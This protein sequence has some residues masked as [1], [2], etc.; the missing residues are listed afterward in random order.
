[1]VGGGDSVTQQ[2]STLT[3][4][5]L[6]TSHNN[7]V[8]FF[9][10]NNP[11]LRDSERKLEMFSGTGGYDRPKRELEQNQMFAPVKE[12]IYGTPNLP[13]EL[14]KERFIQSNLKTN[15]LPFPQV[16]VA[17]GLNQEGFGSKGADGFH[18]MFRPHIRNVDELRPLSN[19]KVQYEGRVIVGKR[20]SALRRGQIGQVS[21]NR[22]DRYYVNEP[23]RWGIGRANNLEALMEQD[24]A[25]ALQCTDSGFEIGG[26][27]GPAATHV[28]EARPGMEKADYEGRPLQEGFNKASGVNSLH[29]ATYKTSHQNQY[30]RNVA[31]PVK[32]N[33]NANVAI[34]YL[35][36][37]MEEERATTEPQTESNQL[38]VRGAVGEGQMQFFDKAQQT[39]A[40]T[41]S[42][43]DTQ[44]NL[45]GH[46]AD[47]QGYETADYEADFQPTNKQFTSMRGYSGVANRSEIGQ[48]YQRAI[49]DGVRTTTRETVLGALDYTGI[50]RTEAGEPM[51]YA[52][53]F[54]AQRDRKYVNN[55]D[56]KGAAGTA[57][58]ARLVNRENYNNAI[59][60]TRQ[61]RLLHQR[62]PT[63]EKSKNI[64]VG[65]QNITIHARNQVSGIPNQYALSG[66]TG[67]SSGVRPMAPTGEFK[68][69]TTFRHNADQNIEWR[70]DPSILDQFRSNPFTQ[71]L[72][73]Y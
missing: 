7:Q 64:N 25:T 63:Q 24:F 15:V 33:N 44:L 12:N 35:P 67:G 9:S 34:N 2:V 48:G 57:Q 62:A 72:H 55:P 27:Q 73:S 56:Y 43:T 66:G 16:R 46:R 26:L 69:L 52:K 6:D 61:E 29:R 70:I 47:G 1:V 23:A 59:I 30:Q 17:P 39:I 22:P 53:Y 19:P 60:R 41:L 5:S 21:K 40:D 28:T 71:S 20:D 36:G 51:S 45:K 42:N 37:I 4:Q 14:R 11:I 3:G 49:V 31:A 8:P 38:N 50:A 54:A 58:S 13:D 18:S 10:G 32:D 65:S 68:N